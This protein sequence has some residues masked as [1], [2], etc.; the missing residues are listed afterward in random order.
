M[1]SVPPE[2]RLRSFLL[3]ALLLAAVLL[4]S[5]VLNRVGD[6][7]APARMTQAPAAA[8]MQA[9]AARSNAGGANWA[10]SALGEL[11]AGR[12]LMLR[13][14]GRELRF[15]VA[16]DQVYEPGQPEH[17]RWREV[18]AGNIGELLR[19]S[20]LRTGAAGLVLRPVKAGLQREKEPAAPPARAGRE[21]DSRVV[22]TGKWLL[23]HRDRAQALAAMAG[24]GFELVSEPDYARDYLIVRAA[25]GG[26]EAGL[27]AASAL[28]G[29]PAIVSAS[30]LLLRQRQKHFIGE[31]DTQPDDEL[32]PKQWHLKAA[33]AHANKPGSDIRVLPVWLGADTGTP[34]TGQGVRI[35]IVDD[36]LDMLHPDLLP[37]L[38]TEDNHWD[39]NDS[40]PDNDPMG[41]WQNEDFHGTS[42]AGLAAARGGNGIGVTGVAPMATLAGFRLIAHPTD[43]SDDADAMLRGNDVIQIKNNSWGPAPTILYKNYYSELGWSGPLTLAARRTAALTGRD[44]KGVLSVWAS[45]N[46]RDAG[47]QGNKD[48]FSNSIYGI[49][50]GVLN[51]NGTIANYSEGGSHLVC[52]A[53]GASGVVTTDFRGAQG[54]NTGNKPGEL[55]GSLAMRDYTQ[56]FGGTSAA[57]PILS[58]VLAL[59]LEA[60]PALTW[61]DVKEILLRGSMRVDSGNKGWVS[62]HGGSYQFG[63]VAHHELYGGGA[64]DAER[65]VRLAEE[66]VNL[67]PMV[68]HSRTQSP[69]ATIPDNSTAG[70][71]TTFD[72][73]DLADLRVEHVTVTVDIGHS[74]RGDLHITLTSPSGTVSTLAA[75]TSQDDGF[76]Y[77]DWVFS[78]V[79]HWG[80]SAKGVWTLRCQDLA[81]GDTGVLFSAEVRLFGS[82]VTPAQLTQAP[83]S[84]IVAEKGSAT[85]TAGGTGGGEFWYEWSKTGAGIVADPD[86]T[87]TLTNAQLAQAGTYQVKILNATAEESSP[88]FAIGVLRAEV[89]GQSVN[90]GKTAVF[91][92]AAAGPGIVLKWFRGDTELNDDGRVTGTSTPTLTIKKAG[93]G[94]IGHYRCRARFAGQESPELFTQEALLDVRLRPVLS[95]PEMT[96][97]FEAT[98]M[99]GAW[100][101]LRFHAENT[102]TRFTLKGLPKGMKFDTKTG[103]LSGVPAAPGPYTLT[104]TAT[105]ASGASAPFIHTWEVDP[106]PD[107]VAGVFEGIVDRNDF[108][109]AGLGGRVTLSITTSGSYSG[110]LV[111]GAKTHR[112]TGRIT[113]FPDTEEVPYSSTTIKF[114]GKRPQGLMELSVQG[115]L[116]SGYLDD[117][118]NGV[119]HF[120]ARRV[121][122]GPDLQ[123]AH[124]GDHTAHLQLAA[125]HDEEPGLPRGHGY[126]AGTCSA[127][128]VFKWAGRLPDGGSFTAAGCRLKDGSLA[129][130][131]LAARIKGSIQGWLTLAPDTTALTGQPDW[132]RPGQSLLSLDVSGGR[133]TPANTLFDF[134]ILAESSDNALAWFSEDGVNEMFR[135]SISVQP[136]NRVTLSR[137]LV[138]NPNRMTLKLNA[139]KGTFTGA[140]TLP[141]NPARK[142]SLAG[143]LVRLPGTEAGLGWGYF[144]LPEQESGVVKLQ[145]AE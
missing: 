131:A 49:P 8:A 39:W 7:A 95:E 75:K 67:G 4:G 142:G 5:L 76:D 93:A 91:K 108:F 105:N 79:R 114:G 58:G 28:H 34:L 109:N 106:L 115:G 81:R 26:A 63:R 54:Y 44:G 60:N 132:L 118:E 110:S 77:E 16:L 122:W 65:A 57:A 51:A 85:L 143:A 94:D 127:R 11:H 14:N 119:F 103:I 84:V 15:E 138:E 89:A 112:F 10:A 101:E 21:P 19:D 87:F 36:G 134:L 70:V 1:P 42:V 141:G 140:F 69:G 13:E 35:A 62:R 98:A 117:I 102:A 46:D 113:T 53:P 9:R 88:D 2:R 47:D 27:R 33:P 135:Q 38:D 25:Q 129:L 17:Q 82:Q 99:V 126:L 59:M 37:N 123:A 64:V 31:D 144:L 71:T 48:S 72:F 3:P 107:G 120:T 96:T 20:A 6:E 73:S 56:K 111:L 92:T 78:S 83:A 52:V 30:P 18:R 43:D 68:E 61:R 104:L 41:R 12:A 40:P 145:A 90:E 86:D 24:A 139:K 121:E 32:F 97:P 50:A 80:E 137:V 23:Q 22:L 55:T 74:Y 130:H 29:H 100:A 133:Y 66:W 124:T 128:G 45:G 116:L 125:L 136:P